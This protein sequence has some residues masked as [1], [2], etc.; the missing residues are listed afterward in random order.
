CCFFL[1]RKQRSQPR[2]VI[3]A[4]PHHPVVLESFQEPAVHHLCICRWLGLFRIIC[5]FSGISLCDD[6]AVWIGRKRI[7]LSIRTD[8]I[9]T[10]HG[11]PTEQVPTYQIQQ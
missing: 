9:C 1:T 7:W 2:N 5:L 10:D 6:Y 8:C 4:P 3:A 11:E